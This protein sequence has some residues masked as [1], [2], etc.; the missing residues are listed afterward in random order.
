MKIYS[1]TTTIPRVFAS[2]E[3]GEPEPTTMLVP[4]GSPVTAIA[5]NDAATSFHLNYQDE[6]GRTWDASVGIFQI[7]LG[8]VIARV[9]EG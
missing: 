3:A 5:T 6:E 1:A 4:A 2:L 7:E 8:G 9:N